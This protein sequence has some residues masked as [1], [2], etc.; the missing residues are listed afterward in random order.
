MTHDIAVRAVSIEHAEERQVVV[1]RE[2]VCNTAAVL[3]DLRPCALGVRGGLYSM[4]AERA[5]DV[6][7]ERWLP[8]LRGAEF[9]RLAEYIFFAGVFLL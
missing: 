4:A 5:D 6:P 2:R 7:R 3:V 9:A 1:A 8:A